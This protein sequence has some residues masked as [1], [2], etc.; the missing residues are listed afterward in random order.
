MPILSKEERETIIRF[1]D[2]V[3]TC[4]IYTAS[5]VV[6]RRLTKRGYAM[7]PEKPWGWRAREVPIKAL[8]FRRME[9]L[10][11]AEGAA[12]RRGNPTW[13]KKP[14]VEETL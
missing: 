3:K 9:S 10:T 6:A 14:V 7:L 1:D 13:L 4:D 8:S 2:S 12:R 5:P 11:K